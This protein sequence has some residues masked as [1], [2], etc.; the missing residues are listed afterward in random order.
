MELPATISCL[1]G[2]E[3][4]AHVRAAQLSPASYTRRPVSR[5]AR[6]QLCGECDERRRL[7][8]FDGHA[9]RPRPICRPAAWQRAAA[10]ANTAPTAFDTPTLHRKQ[11]GYDLLR[12]GSGA[13]HRTACAFAGAST[14]GA[15]SA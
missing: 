3:P 8:G 7:L 1:M 2:L 9:P 14:S 12:L 4:L 11:E 10:L 13:G 5:P 15:G 6:P